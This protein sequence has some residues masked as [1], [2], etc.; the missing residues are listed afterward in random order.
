MAQLDAAF[1]EAVTASK[2]RCGGPRRV[3]VGVGRRNRAARVQDAAAL[4]RAVDVSGL[5]RTLAASTR[6]SQPRA[7][8]DDS[9]IVPKAMNTVPLHKQQRGAMLELDDRNCCT[10]G[11]GRAH[12]RAFE[13]QRGMHGASVGKAQGMQ[14]N[15]GPWTGVP[16]C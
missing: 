3:A 7:V 11:H 1:A 9:A 13:I 5:R 12:T 14:G 4:P 10:A 2:S 6:M 15:A 16:S 8:A